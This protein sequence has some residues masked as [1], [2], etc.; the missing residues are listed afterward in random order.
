MYHQVVGGN[1]A[2]FGSYGPQAGDGDATITADAQHA[3][4]VAFVDEFFTRNGW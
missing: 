3:E 2:G 1:H 4:V